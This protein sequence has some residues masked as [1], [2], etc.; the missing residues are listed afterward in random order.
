M[1]VL[2]FTPDRNTKVADYSGAFKPEA[3]RFCTLY[4]GM[5]V[6][7]PLDK[8]LRFQQETCLGA[9][10]GAAQNAAAAGKTLDCVAFFC[11][12]FTPRLQFAW[13]RP[14]VGRLAQALAEVGCRRVALY[15]CSA[16]GGPGPGGDG[17]FADVLRDAMCIVGMT[18]ARVLAHRTSGHTTWNPRKRFFEGMGSPVGGTG[19]F[20]IVGEKSPLWNRWRKRLATPK[21][22]LRFQINFMSVADIHAELLASPAS[23]A[24]R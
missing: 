10:Q 24:I 15:A 3:M 13:S 17:G 9:I 18:D 2:A 23:L 14:N 11:H 1:A 5:R 21:D 4:G 22:T 12:G 20:D 16:A 6:E 8:P 7:V 19:G